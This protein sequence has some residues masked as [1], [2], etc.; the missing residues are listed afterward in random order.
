[1]EREKH[2]P[3][4]GVRFDDSS[5]K[6]FVPATPI[7]AP[8]AKLPIFSCHLPI[9][10]EDWICVLSLLIIFHETRPSLN[11]TKSVL[12]VHTEDLNGEIKYKLF[13]YLTNIDLNILRYSLEIFGKSIE[14]T[15]N[16]FV[17]N[18]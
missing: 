3:E 9:D 7:A 1:M 16:I 15:R 8:I 11:F 12:V 14:T 6:W 10:I 4:K 17:T 5:K 2:A 13:L 18:V